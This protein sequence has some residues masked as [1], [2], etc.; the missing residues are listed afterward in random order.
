MGKKRISRSRKRDLE[1]PDEFITFWTKLFNFASENKVL[2]SGILGFFIVLIVVVSGSA[3]YLKTSEDR[4]F[5]LLQ[6]AIN[7]YQTALG[8]NGPYKAYLEVDKEFQSILEKYPRRKGG[9]LARLIYANICYN[10]DNYDKAIDLYLSSLADFQNEP[11]LKNI[12]LNSLGYAY[13]GKKDYQT[14]AT[15]FEKVVAEANATL[16]DDALFHLG[17]LYAKM[18]YHDK[19]VE[20]FRKILSNH[21]DSMYIEIAKEKVKGYDL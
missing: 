1:Q 16:K 11:Y 19:S 3:Y 21:T 9:K 20:A 2:L 7:T 13:K 6:Y 14:A 8:S 17:D 10:A 18:G 15:F 12:V 5:A 4:S